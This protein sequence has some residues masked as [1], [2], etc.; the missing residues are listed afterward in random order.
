VAFATATGYVVFAGGD[1]LDWK[2]NDG[3]L[4]MV[5]GV[6]SVVDRAAG[7]VPTAK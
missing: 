5:E 6:G 7:V 1:Y 4:D 2:E 3:L